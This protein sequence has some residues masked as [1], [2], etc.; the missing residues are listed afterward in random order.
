MKERQVQ[1]VYYLSRNGQLEHPHFMELTLT[2]P[3]LHL[4]D[5]LQRLVSLRGKDMP[6]L[7]SWSCKR[8]YKHGYVWNDLSYNDVVY[9]S[10]PPDEYVLKGSHLPHQ[11]IITQT[12][13]L[14]DEELSNSNSSSNLSSVTHTPP[15]KSSVG[16]STDD[17]DDES[18]QVSALS[19]SSCDS[20]KCIV[21]PSRNSVLL[22]LVACGGRSNRCG[23]KMMMKSVMDHKEERK[24]V[25]VVCK[26][27]MK[28][29]S[30]NNSVDEEDKAMIKCMSENPRFGGFQ[31]ENKEYFSGSIVEDM[32]AE[33]RVI[34]EP[35]FM[36]R[37]NSFTEERCD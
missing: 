1:V 37:S 34:G 12:L 13:T 10:Q 19:S 6:S 11:N 14:E 21:E 31:T 8:S 4:K 35:R 7:Y 5:V 36:K 33:V 26:S 32:S 27:P 23:M 15:S 18:L 29:C 25:V 22:Q 3:H 28:S 24:V 30:N 20:D 16:I 17:I 9:P 2:S